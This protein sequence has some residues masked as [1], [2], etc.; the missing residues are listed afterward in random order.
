MGT[1]DIIR[2]GREYHISPHFIYKYNLTKDALRRARKNGLPYIKESGVYFYNENDFHD[3]FAGRI[4][5]DVKRKQEVN[6][7]N[8][9]QNN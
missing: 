1:G 7:G 5:N 2:G 9:H 3:Y 8:T 4:G 6:H